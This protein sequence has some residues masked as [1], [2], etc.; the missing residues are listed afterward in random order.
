MFGDDALGSKT[1]QWC[2]SR[3]G[4]WL[5]KYG[6]KQRVTKKTQ[7]FGTCISQVNGIW[8]DQLNFTGTPVR[9]VYARSRARCCHLCQQHETQLIAFHGEYFFII[10]FQLIKPTF[11][12]DFAVQNKVSLIQTLAVVVTIALFLPIDEDRHPHR[13]KCACAYSPSTRTHTQKRHSS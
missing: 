2:E 3:I 8:S 13:T 10:I 5:F 12:L 11:G 9:D 1:E 7:P 6:Q 4:W